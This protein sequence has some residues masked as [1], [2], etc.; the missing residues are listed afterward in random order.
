MTRTMF[1]LLAAAVLLSACMTW[2]ARGAPAKKSDRICAELNKQDPAMIVLAASN[3]HMVP[4]EAK[5]HF[6]SP[7]QMLAKA[8]AC[9]RA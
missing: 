3:W 9:R 4:P 8:R 1:V 7:R 2:P 6:K 5:R